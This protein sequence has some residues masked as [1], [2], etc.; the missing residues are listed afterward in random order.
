[1]S[2]VKEI[3]TFRRLKHEGKVSPI[4]KFNFHLIL[5]I[6]VDFDGVLGKE[7]AVLFLAL[8]A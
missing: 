2:I 3:Q 1:M 7:H 8:L 6:I 4:V 5:K